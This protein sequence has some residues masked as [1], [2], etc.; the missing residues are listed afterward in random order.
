MINQTVKN[1]IRWLEF[2]TPFGVMST[3]ERLALP[4]WRW[5]TILQDPILEGWVL[6]F[7]FIFGRIVP[8]FDLERSL[9]VYT[10]PNEPPSDW[11]FDLFA[12]FLQ[13]RQDISQQCLEAI[14]ALQSD[15]QVANGDI[16]DPPEL[17]EAAGRVSLDIDSEITRLCQATDLTIYSENFDGK[18]FVK[19]SFFWAWDEEHHPNLLFYNGKCIASTFDEVFMD[20]QLSKY[21]K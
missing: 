10:R 3:T 18:G 4:S 14:G 15:F 17:Y 1:G 11:Q 12:N 8:G 20:G 19:L 9:A 2:D 7:Q 5:E 6:E 16:V 13:N 21:V